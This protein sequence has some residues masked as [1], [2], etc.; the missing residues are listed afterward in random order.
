MAVPSD[1]LDKARQSPSGGN[2]QPWHVVVV[3]GDRL[4]KLLAAIKGSPPGSEKPEYEIYPSGLVDLYRSRRSANGEAMY[5]SMDLERED[6]AG[7][8]M[9]LARNFEFFGALSACSSTRRASWGRHNGLTW[10]CGCKL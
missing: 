3:S 2:V 1:C 4:E 5:T 10:V 7:R 6:K 8:M 9:H